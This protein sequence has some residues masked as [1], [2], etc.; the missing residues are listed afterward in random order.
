MS[1]QM[2]EG[3]ICIAYPGIACPGMERTAVTNLRIKPGN[4]LIHCS[5]GLSA[6]QHLQAQ[7]ESCG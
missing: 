7:D 1:C 4:Q 2:Q 5:V 6:N 3:R